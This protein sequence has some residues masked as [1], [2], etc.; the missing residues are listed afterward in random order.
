MT[1]KSSLPGVY[2]ATKKNG[3][4]YYRSSLTYHR[5]HIS[6][7]SF[8]TMKAAHS[9]YVEALELLSDTSKTIHSYSAKNTLSFEKWVSLNNLRDNGIYFSNP[10][11]LRK[12]FFEYY[13]A[14][15]YILKFDM[16]DLFYYSSHKIMRR[17]GHLFVAD[18]GMQLNIANRY[19]IKNYALPGRDFCFVNQDSTDFRY[20]N[21][22]I[23]NTY[24]GVSRVEIKGHAKY[25]AKIHI[26]GDYIIGHY[27]TATEAAIAYNKAIDIL[28]KAGCTKNYTSNYL[29]NISP[30]VYA[31]I[32]SE[33][34]ISKK[35]LNY[36]FDITSA[37]NQ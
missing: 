9:S 8:D 11:Y 36:S 23:Y 13:L 26:H 27:S 18:Y 32:Y 2:I 28:K 16:D 21:I 35:V 14:E 17:G 10:I 1:V 24:Y 34:S 3:T 33:L 29:E 7:G 37:N 4:I 30:K 25:R 22:E 19:G 31:D 6:L 5:K 12:N 20:E 15:D